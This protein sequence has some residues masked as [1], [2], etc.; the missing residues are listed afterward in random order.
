MGLSICITETWSGITTGISF[1]VSAQALKRVLGDESGPYGTQHTPE[2]LEEALNQA[3]TAAARIL[4]DEA[5]QKLQLCL[6]SSLVE[7]LKKDLE[8][9]GP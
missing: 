9:S 8:T 2:E 3:V 1:A 4:L 5:R 7:H 6:L